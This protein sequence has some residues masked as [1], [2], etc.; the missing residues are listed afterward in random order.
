MTF[1]NEKPAEKPRDP[2]NPEALV[3]FMMT[4]WKPQAKPLPKPVA[5]LPR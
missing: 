2:N 3:R 4:E 5:A 1:Q